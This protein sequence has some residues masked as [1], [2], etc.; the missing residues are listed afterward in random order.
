MQSYDDFHL[1]PRNFPITSPTC[2]DTRPKRRQIGQTPSKLVV[3][4]CFSILFSLISQNLCTFAIKYRLIVVTRRCY[5]RELEQL[6][7]AAVRA[8]L[9]YVQDSYRGF[10]YR[11]E[12]DVKRYMNT[13]TTRSLF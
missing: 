2:S 8:V 3:S 7:R 5:G 10:S 4:Q 9:D 12:C 6:L 13:F 1:Q 11:Q